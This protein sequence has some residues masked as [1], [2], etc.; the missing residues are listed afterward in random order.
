MQGFVELLNS[1]LLSVVEAFTDSNLRQ[2]T[3]SPTPNIM[4]CRQNDPRKGGIVRFDV[5]F[6]EYFVREYF[7]RGYFIR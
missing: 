1:A 6:R 5:Y 3:P 7:V 4:L 2:N